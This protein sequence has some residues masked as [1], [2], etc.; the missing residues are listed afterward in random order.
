MKITIENATL[1]KGE[2][3]KL[4]TKIEEVGKTTNRSIDLE[5][6]NITIGAVFNYVKSIYEVP[7]EDDKTT[8]EPDPA[9]IDTVLAQMLNTVPLSEE[10]K[11]EQIK[12]QHKQ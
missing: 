11:E 6:K 9:Y 4:M 3:A 5:L 12:I 1:S 2:F 8:Y 10:A 7:V